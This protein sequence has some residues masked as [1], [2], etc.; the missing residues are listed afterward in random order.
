MN[1]VASKFI[2]PNI[3]WS[4]K[5]PKKSFTK[6]DIL[7]ECQKHNN[8]LFV[9]FITKQTLK[10]LLED[11][12]SPREADTFLDGVR[13]FYRATYE[14]YTKWLPL[15]NDILKSCIFIDFSKD[16][17][18]VLMMCY[19]VWVH[20]LMSRRNNSMLIKQCL[21]IKSHIMFGSQQKLMKM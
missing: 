12:I 21:G 17:D 7:L 20:F 9:G 13:A 1:K 18:S 19:L 4:W 5:L 6:L 14:C 2:K 11:E 8:D 16:Q 15:D 10:K 3:F